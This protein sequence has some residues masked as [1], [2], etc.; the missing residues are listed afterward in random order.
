M[1]NAERFDVA[2][3]GASIAG[4]TAA[5]LFARTGA[6]VALIERRPDPA[7]HKVVC[8]HAIQ[9]SATPTIERLGLAPLL[10]ARGAVHIRGDAWTRFGWIRA[11]DDSPHGYGVTRRTLDPILRSLAA[12]TPGVELLT[13]LT[14]TGLLG[15]GRPAGVKAQNGKGAHRRIAAGLVVAADGRGST[16]AR[17]AGVRGRVLPHNRFFYWAYW[18]GVHPVTSRA[19]I[20]LLDPDGGAHFPNEDGLALLAIGANREHL[21]AYRSDLE[22]EYLRHLRALPDGPEVGDARRVS[23][24]I[25]KVEM[26]NVLRPAARPGLAF[27]G[28]AAL[29]ADPLFGVGCGWAF[30]SAEWLVDA[31][32][33]ALLGE[34]DLDAALRRY[35]RTF[36]R[37]MVPHHLVISDY[38]TGRTFTPAERLVFRAAARDAVVRRALDD[39]A[40][41]RRSPL[42]ML[43]P[44]LTPRLILRGAA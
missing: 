11:P 6:R 20:W 13:G 33:P 32:A 10:D 42:R 35:R 2:V 16:V 36:W 34:G 30:Q 17:L 41:R 21:P 25:G 9:P 28:D 18:E 5:R 8:T 4:C 38:S 24:I 27:V 23:K 37:R 29:A 1:G 14:A 12:E 22:G 3:V 19:R 26:P 31:A 40:S 43:D 7:A 15:D 39:V 44:R